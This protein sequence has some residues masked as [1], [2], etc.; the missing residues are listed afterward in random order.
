M[1]AGNLKCVSGDREALLRA[2]RF[3][4]QYVRLVG[5]EPATGKCVLV[6]T[7]R[8]VRKDMKDWV[9]SHEDQKWAVKLDFRDLGG[10]LDSTFRWWFS[11]L[12]ARVRLAI[13]GMCFLL[14]FHWISIA[15]SGRQDYVHPLCSPWC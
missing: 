14:F 5:Q 11:T 1:Y 8:V 7:S 2:A 10:H 12:A 3:T 15:G 6:S 4:T 13:L 9:L